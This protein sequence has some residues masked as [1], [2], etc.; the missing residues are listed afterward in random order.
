MQALMQVW[1]HRVL[2]EEGVTLDISLSGRSMKHSLQAVVSSTTD[3]GFKHHFATS[4]KDPGFM[5]TG[6]GAV[7]LFFTRRAS[8]KPA[9]QGKTTTWLLL[10]AL[11][12]ESSAHNAGRRRIPLKI[13]YV[14]YSHRQKSRVRAIGT[15]APDLCS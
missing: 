14:Q 7:H 15:V 8:K 12:R 4:L 1:L 2:I 13:E 3:C 5:T 6:F 10:Y 11:N 9:T